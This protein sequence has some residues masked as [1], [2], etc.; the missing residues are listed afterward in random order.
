VHPILQMHYLLA[1]N[2]DM[3]RL[4]TVNAYRDAAKG[5]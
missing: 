3:A 4:V 1:C 2:P 5:A